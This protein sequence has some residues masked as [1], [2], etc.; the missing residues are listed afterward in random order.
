MAIDLG[1]NPGH[2]V[3]MRVTLP[4]A[5]YPE[6]SQ[7]MAFHQD[8]L[9]RVG[10]LPA[11]D[12]IG[13]N[14]AI[15]LEGGG[16]E[17]EVMYEGQ[18]PPRSAHEEATMCLFQ[19]STPD[20][21]RAMGIALI[22]GRPFT[23][24]DTADSVRVAIVDDTLVRKLYPNVDPIGK[25]IAFEFRGTG[26]TDP[27][28]IWREIVG[29]VRHVR[30]YGLIAEPPYVQVYTPL[31]QIPIWFHQRRPSMALVARTTLEPER[32]ASS[33]RQQVMAIDRD[34]PVHAVQTMDDYVAQ[35]T[36]TS[37]L[38]V[39][40]LAAFGALALVLAVLGIYG[41][42]SYLVSLRTRE[43]GIRIALGAT[44]RDV[45]RLIV[46]H[47]MALTGLGLACGL[48]G[49]WAITASMRTLLFGISPHDPITFA[50]IV[51]LLT[52][53]AFLASYVP[54]RRATR[55]DPVVTLRDE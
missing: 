13:L 52:S 51:A 54:G 36:E 27:Q 53:V 18:P 9:R 5:K 31:P 7:W 20:Y 35:T 23:D 42:L 32:L 37:R 40:L 12:A 44:R 25:R 14:S 4:A 47:G 50:S 33:I 6:L 29:V 49:S 24:R 48:A 2:V 15:P 17:S 46:G 1:F 55:V 41:V 8:L 45:M 28:P 34:I 30:H 43:I 3:T 39:M 38:S 11:I 22:K 19:T 26:P 21:F 10:T 16:S